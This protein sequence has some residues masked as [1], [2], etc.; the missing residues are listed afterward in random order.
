MRIA[1]L[2]YN[3]LETVSGGYLYDR[4]LVE[5]LRSQGD[6]VEVIT[7]P[8]RN[9]AAHLNDNFSHALFNQLRRLQV[10]ILLQDEL[11]HPSLFLINRRL[12]KVV[13]FPFV[14]IV[15]HLRSNEYRP[16][17]QNRLYRLV[18][19]QYLRYVD[20]LVFNSHTTRQTV[21]QLGIPLDNL[22]SL[23]AYPAGDRFNPHLN[24]LSIQH[25]ALQPGPLKILFIG[26]LISRKGL[27]IL[28][29]ALHGLPDHMV[30]LSI[31]GNPSVDARYAR[32]M[33]KLVSE[34]GLTQI[35]GFLG[36]THDDRLT[37]ILAQSQLLVVPSSY[38]GFGIVYLEGMSFGLPAI[39]TLSGGAAEI[40]THGV[41]GF[42]TQ[43]GDVARLRAHL[44]DLAQN[45]QKLAV[46]GVAARQRFE[47]H[48]GWEETNQC[49][50]E[51]LK[52]VSQNR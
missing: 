8:W 40:I 25:R 45:R 33:Q 17:W 12:R 28:L 21:A 7:I 24:A 10:D 50:R 42:L 39:G 37:E 51:F 30:E 6:Q 22:P 16:K 5:Y 52:S 1:L 18:E 34:F 23:I 44:V 2:I 35:V 48:P 36:M 29:Q 13:P 26:N 27:H 4:K 46:M 47:S 31:I 15:H 41:D 11:N 19:R 9:Y 20:A 49:I 38:E 14:S 43:P 3:S 32:K